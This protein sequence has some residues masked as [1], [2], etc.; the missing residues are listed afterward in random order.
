AGPRRLGVPSH[1]ARDGCDDPRATPFARAADGAGADRDDPC[2][3]SRLCA[4]DP[5][6][7]PDLPRNAHAAAQTQRR[8]A[9]AMSLSTAAR[10]DFAGGE[11]PAQNIAFFHQNDPFARQGGIESYVA[12]LLNRAEGRAML[13]SAPL[14]QPRA[15][16]FAAAPAGPA[17]A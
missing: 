5:R 6:R 7:L 8:S 13:V 3:R 1:I 11:P 4:R 9:G 17:H 12:T 16:Y 2:G 15:D 10:I 14:R